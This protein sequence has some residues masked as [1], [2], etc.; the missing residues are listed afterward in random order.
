[1]DSTSGQDQAALPN[2]SVPDAG[3]SISDDGS[4][5]RGALVAGL[6]G[7]VVATAGYVIYN[8]LEHEQKEAV[9]K[10]VTKFV[11]ERVGE[12]RSMLKI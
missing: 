10:T 11:E 6:I 12:V 5:L 8:R 7:A 1:M 9:R 4:E 3:R 2:G